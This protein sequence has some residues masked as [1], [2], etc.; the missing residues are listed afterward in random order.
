M[1]AYPYHS[2][3]AV[4]WSI[5]SRPFQLNQKSTVIRPSMPLSSLNQRYF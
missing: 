4:R 5:S 2:S 3:F 1:E